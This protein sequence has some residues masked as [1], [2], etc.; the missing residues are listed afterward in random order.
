MALL[1]KKQMIIYGYINEH[2]KLFNMDIPK[3]I[4]DVIV[5]FY[6]LFEWDPI[7][8]NAAFKIDGNKITATSGGWISA[9]GTNYVSSG[10][11]SWKLKVNAQYVMIGI[12]AHESREKGVDHFWK[13]PGG[14]GYFCDKDCFRQK[15]I[16]YEEE[17]NSYGEYYGRN[18][19]ITVHLNLDK[20]QLSFSKNNKN[21]GVIPWKMSKNKKYHL[22]IAICGKNGAMEFINTIREK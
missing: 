16:L 8:S 20:L 14:F 17:W 12:I 6:A 11:I 18:D 19:I 21:L 2:N 1:K 7:T 9:F 22:A 3:D 5:L 13:A 4:K 15:G 10:R